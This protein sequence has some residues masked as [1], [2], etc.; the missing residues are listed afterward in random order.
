MS[1]FNDSIDYWVDNRSDSYTSGSNMCRILRHGVGEQV[2]LFTEPS[3]VSNAFPCQTL[4]IFAVPVPKELETFALLG[5]QRQTGN[6]SP[7]TC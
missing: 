7:E 5:S 6:S 4:V 1:N 3:I 2:R